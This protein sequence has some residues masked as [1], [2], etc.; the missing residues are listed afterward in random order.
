MLWPANSAGEESRTHGTRHVTDKQNSNV[1]A[2]K[3]SV[4]IWSDQLKLFETA[5]DKYGAIDIVYANAGIDET[6][7]TFIDSFDSNGKLEEPSLKTLDVSLKGAIFTA[8]LALSYFHRND[9]AGALVFTGSAASYLDTRGIPIYNAAKHGV[10]GLARSLRETATE[11]GRGTR[12]NVVAPA[13]VNTA[14]TKQLLPIWISEKLPINE[15]EHVARA[16]LFS[17]LNTEWHGKGIYI[18][19]GNFTELEQ[20]ILDLRD[21]WL[22][23]ENTEWVDRRKHKHIKLG[24]QDG[25]P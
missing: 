17:G 10:L 9:K 11:E 12:V 4:T 24:K 5:Q 7:G 18:A 25:K 21:S 22:G 15:P 19:A 13:F 2:T 3:G 1:T 14:F 20:P 6:A 23:K 16:L 8:K